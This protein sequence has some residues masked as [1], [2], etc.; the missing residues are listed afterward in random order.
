MLSGETPI[1]QTTTGEFVSLRVY[2][3]LLQEY[4][5]RSPGHMQIFILGRCSHLNPGYKG[6]S[7]VG[8]K[9]RATFFPVRDLTSAKPPTSD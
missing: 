9:V 5:E 3:A 8:A 7:C 6:E 1:L 4:P 2:T